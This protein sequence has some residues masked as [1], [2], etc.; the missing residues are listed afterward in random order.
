MLFT[1]PGVPCIYYGDETGM[2]G[3]ADP[4]NR[5]CF[6][7]DRAHWDLSL[8][9]YFKLL[10]HTRSQRAEWRSGAV[11]TLAVA[12]DWLA[13]ARF[14]ADAASVVVVNRGPAQAVRVPLHGLP[15]WP[16]AWRTLS[17][18]AARVE[19]DGL[20]AGLHAALYADLPAAGHAVWLSA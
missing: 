13:Y 8:F 5:R 3:G 20:Y 4:D 12:D 1:R 7:W 15:W 2:L 11:L 14:T 17:G 6:D 19:G 18:P 10:A 9:E 16:A